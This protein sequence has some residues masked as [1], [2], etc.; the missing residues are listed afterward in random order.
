LMG[1]GLPSTG[2]G[3]DVADTKRLPGCNEELW[4]WQLHAV[5]RG[6]DSSVFFSPDTERGP[7]RRRREAAAKAICA[8][9]PVIANCRAHALQVHEPYGIWGGLTE[10]ERTGQPAFAMR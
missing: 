6:M 1:F 8:G 5:C 10:N 2:I 7:R 4:E 9:C 3:G